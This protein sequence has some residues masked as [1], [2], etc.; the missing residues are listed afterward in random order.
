MRRS[1]W[2]LWKFVFNCGV[3]LC[4]FTC[5]Y[6]RGTHVVLYIS[7]TSKF[8]PTKKQH[9]MPPVIAFVLNIAPFQNKCVPLWTFPLQ[10]SQFSQDVCISFTLYTQKRQVYLAWVSN[11]R[12]SRKKRLFSYA[13]TNL[14]Q[15]FRLGLGCNLSSALCCVCS[16]HSLCLS[17]RVWLLSQCSLKHT[18]TSYEYKFDLNKYLPK[19]STNKRTKNARQKNNIIFSLSLALIESKVS[20]DKGK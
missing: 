6:A 12:R 2:K 10:T 3:F 7:M 11:R 9:S 17:N 20:I 19:I 8:D 5:M 1:F 13:K 14:N 18:H 15:S 16:I 4:V